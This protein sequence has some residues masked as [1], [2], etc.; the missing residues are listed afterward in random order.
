M[1]PVVAMETPSSSLES[2]SRLEHH[3]EDDNDRFR[4]P[5]VERNYHK[6][7]ASLYTRRLETTTKLLEDRAKEK[8][9]KGRDY[10]V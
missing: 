10:L 6:Q 7:F 8:W 1:P 5:V 4:L 3:F 2:V 9:G